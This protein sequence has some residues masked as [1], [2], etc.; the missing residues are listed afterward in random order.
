MA[1]FNTSTWTGT[2]SGNSRKWRGYMNYTWGTYSS[3]PNLYYEFILGSTGIEKTTTGSAEW[4]GGTAKVTITT[5]NGQIQSKSQSL[6]SN[7]INWS[8]S[9]NVKKT[10]SQATVT[11]IAGANTFSRTHSAYNISVTVSASKSGGSAWNGSTSSTLTLTVPAKPSY[12][13]SYNANGGS[14]APGNQTKWYGENLT[15]STTKP[16]RAGYQF[17]GWW[18]AASGGSQYG[19]TYTAN[20]SATLYAHWTPNTYTLRYHVNGGSVTASGYSSSNSLVTYNSSTDFHKVSYNNSSDTYNTTTF[21]LSRVGYHFIDGKEWNRASNGSGTSYDH[22]VTYAWTIF[23]STSAASTIVT[24]YANWVGNTYTINYDANGGTGTMSSSTH[25]YGTAKALTTNTFSRT[26][27]DFVGWNTASDGSGNSYT[28]GQSVSNLIS[29]DNGSITLYAQWQLKTYI[30]SYNLNGGTGLISNQ[31]KTYN[32]DITLHDGTGLSYD[33]YLLAYWKTDTGTSYALGA[34]YSVE[35]STTLYAQWIDIIP[36][37]NVEDIERVTGAYK[38]STDTIVD[39][40]KIYYLQSGNGTTTSH[41]YNRVE[42]ATGNPSENEPPY[43]EAT[44][45][46]TTLDDEGTSAIITATFT[47]TNSYSNI[48]TSNIRIYLNKPQVIIITANE[49]NSYSPYIV[50][51]TDPNLTT[52][53]EVNWSDTSNLTSP[54]TLY[55]YIDDIFDTQSSYPFSITPKDSL[56]SN[57]Q[58]VLYTG[59]NISFILPMAYYTIDFLAGGHGIAFGTAAQHEGL[60]IRFP[61]AIGL[62]LQLPTKTENN[63]TMIDIDKYQLVVGQYNERK[64]D[65][66]FIIGNGSS[67]NNRYNALE[68]APNGIINVYKAGDGDGILAAHLRPATDGFDWD[69][70]IAINLTTQETD[71]YGTG[72]AIYNK[73]NIKAATFDVHYYDSNDSSNSRNN[74]MAAVIGAHRVI[75]DED[76]R[77]QLYLNIENDGSISYGLTDREAFKNALGLNNLLVDANQFSFQGTNTSICTVN[78]SIDAS[79]TNNDVSTT[80]WPNYQILDKS[81]RILTRYE[82]VI[83][84]NGSIGFQIYARQYNTSGTMT[85]QGGIAGHIAQG[86]TTMTY[87]IA[88]PANFRSAIGAAASSDRRLKTNLIPLGKEAV[89]FVK[90]LKPY[91]YTINNEKQIGF[92]A[93]DIYKSDKWNTHM[94]FETKEGIDGLDDWE[95]MSDGSPTWKLD[96]IR[97]IPALT[98]ALQDSMKRIDELEITIEELKTTI[99]ELKK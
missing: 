14:G 23:G 5:T 54:C 61:T 84:S 22:D 90:E 28:N 95:I 65:P 3:N 92:I 45:D 12:T 10:L 87:T 9:A 58:S 49:N 19:T 75:N 44:T 98:A 4:S 86:A 25:T 53:S 66:I 80:L 13:V 83:N 33:G 46:K 60:V 96:Y 89:Q 76:V 56:Y 11:E 38:L 68:I 26:G 39:S 6:S 88:D 24:L 43:Y 32:T 29:T 85:K 50:W 70:D 48:T 41:V 17:A 34:T 91:S 42:T 36:R 74:T 16:T 63:Q 57:G 15:L 78:T 20:A 73:N 71:H 7:A 62:G 77:N 8:S 69:T 31:T 18:T 37:V 94:A 51:Y 21:G 97:I 27:Y 67:D 59:T 79:K 30:I 82:G 72:F 93:Q 1:I 47:W 35:E 99:E 55:G 2:Y 64:N 52:A 40:N 81:R